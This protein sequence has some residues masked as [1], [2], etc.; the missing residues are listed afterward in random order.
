LSRFK[1]GFENS[2]FQITPANIAASITSHRWSSLGRSNI[3]YPPDFNLTFRSRAF[4][5]SSST[6]EN[7][8]YRTFSRVM[9]DDRT[10][11]GTK[12][13]GK[14]KQSMIFSFESRRTYHYLLCINP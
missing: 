12:T 5:I 11:S 14:F 7:I 6:H 3:K 2:L 9:L 4:L 1:I 8:K 10:I 13:F